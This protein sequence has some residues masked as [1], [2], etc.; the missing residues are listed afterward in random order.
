MSAN[1]GKKEA[2]KNKYTTAL[3]A[4]VVAGGFLYSGYSYYK[5]NILG[6]TE[7]EIKVSQSSSGNN[8]NRLTFISLVLSESMVE[9]ENDKLRLKQVFK[10]LTNLTIVLH[11]YLQK[12]DILQ[13]L[14]IDEEEDGF[15]I[16]ETSKEESC[17]H[18]LK[19]IGS[20]ISIFK[21]KDFSLN[22]NEIEE[23]HLNSFLSNI[24]DLDNYSS[25][26]EESDNNS[27]KITNVFDFLDNYVK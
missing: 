10:G 11:P 20:S 27:S 1:R 26:S 25:N 5:K 16:I 15:R 14:D 21:S 8:K 22:Q 17:F 6:E 24:I 7:D 3:A 18:I 12:Q 13:I 19:Q 2:T 4:L 9:S 23:F